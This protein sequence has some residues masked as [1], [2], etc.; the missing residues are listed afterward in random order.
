MSAEKQFQLSFCSLSLD[1]RPTYLPRIPCRFL[2]ATS[3]TGRTW[4]RWISGCHLSILIYWAVLAPSA[5]WSSI[6]VAL[7]WV[8]FATN[9]GPGPALR[10]CTTIHVPCQEMVSRDDLCFQ[11]SSLSWHLSHPCQFPEL[12][13]GEKGSIMTPTIINIYSLLVS[14]LILL[15]IW[16]Q[17]ILI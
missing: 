12:S 5:L 3:G 1:F 10:H 13:C 15:P 16:V 2:E 14:F 6:H 7:C 8:L 4:G 17:E 11:S 9:R